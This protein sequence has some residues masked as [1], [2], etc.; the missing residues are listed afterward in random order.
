MVFCVVVHVPDDNSGLFGIKGEL[1]IGAH[2]KSSQDVTIS[3]WL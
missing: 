1:T 3:H 2:N